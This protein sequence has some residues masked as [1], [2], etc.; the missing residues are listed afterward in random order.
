MIMRKGVSPVVA[1][2]LLIAIAVISAVAVWTW[3]G[4]LTSKPPMGSTTQY[5]LTVL[6]CYPGT[7]NIDVKN[8]GGTRITGVTFLLINKT[9]GQQS[10]S[11]TGLLTLA[12]GDVNSSMSAG[13]VLVSGM[14]YALRAT[15]FPDIEWTC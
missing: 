15:N 2:V 12:P 1:I 7:A 6:K 9:D 10:G 5:S 13:A 8:T 3:V 4:P 14:P 11:G